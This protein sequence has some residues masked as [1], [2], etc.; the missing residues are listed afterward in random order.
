[1]QGSATWDL[2]TWLSIA[3]VAFVVG[4]IIVLSERWHGKLTGDTDMDKP[5]ASHLRPAPRVGGLAIWAGSL[6]GLLVLGPSNMTLTWLWPVLFIAALP[7]FV[8]GVVEDISKD[9]GS[10]KRLLA[11]FASAAIAWWLLGG[12]VRVDVEWANWLLSFWPIS[13][14]FTVVAVGGCTHA[15]NI[16]D[17]ING[18]AGMVAV[19]MAASL[20]AVAWQVQDYPI[21]LIA[22]SLA[23]STLG[24]LA[25]NFPFG[26]V[27]LGDGG[28]YF[29]GF[30]L[31][32]LAVLLVVRNP[33]ISPFYAL[34]VLF[35]PVFE[36]MFS[37][38]RRLFKRNVPV[39][40]PDSLHLHQLVFRRLVR[41]S[42]LREGRRYVPPTSNAMASPYLWG[43]VL[44]GLVPATIWWDNAWML[45][46]SLLVFSLCYIWLYASLVRWRRPRWLLLP[47]VR[48][49]HGRQAQDEASS[50]SAAGTRQDENSTPSDPDPHKQNGG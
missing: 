24:F 22:T 26:R 21:V 43:L 8:A 32:E 34:A 17:G 13:L 30:M 23:F 28:A 12:V 48:R 6:A 11:A 14:I 5:Q 33:S 31:A 16:I 39:D 25:W 3:T 7:V 4:G 41:V 44:I 9:V 46:L 20:A 19:L 38:W 15:L 45:V 10:L 18:L 36:T 29:L 37:I 42:V 49:A 1:M 47:S 35:Y 50:H 27:F 40:Q 2:V